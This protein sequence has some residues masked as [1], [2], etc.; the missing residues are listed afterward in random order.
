[1]ELIS[2]GNAVKLL[3]VN[4]KPISSITFDKLVA[5][6]EITVEMTVNGG[7]RLFDEEKIKTLAKRFPSSL[8]RGFALILKPK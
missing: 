4:G 2:F 1:M 8:G 6:G 3:K 5:K 7:W